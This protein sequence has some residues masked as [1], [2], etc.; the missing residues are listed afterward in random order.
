MPNF[1]IPDEDSLKEL[2][3]M[4]IGDEPQI[5]DAAV[6]ADDQ[7]SHM[8]KFVDDED[9]LVGLCLSDLPLSAALASG[10][11]MIPPAAAQEMVQEKEL[12]PIATDNLY[13][14]MN[15]LSSLYMNDHTPHL[16]LTD[17]TAAELDGIAVDS[18]ERKDYLI[19]AGKYGQGNITFLAM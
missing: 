11:S 17:V 7:F 9:E 14:I 5:G 12:T 2:L 15:M 8:A 19:E 10:L 16:R 4:V 6:A 13:E 18:F 3:T 1:K